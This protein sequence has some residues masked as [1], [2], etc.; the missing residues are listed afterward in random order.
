MAMSSDSK[1]QSA[2]APTPTDLPRFV[3]A[4]P[5]LVAMQSVVGR[6]WQPVLLYELAEAEALGF[7]DLKGRVDGVSSKMLSES[8][9]RLEA[10]GLVARRL[11]NEKPVRVEYRLTDA[12]TDLVPVLRQLVAWGSEHEPTQGDEERSA[13][14]QEGR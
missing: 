12:G 5:V 2:D 11:L 14:P 7:S 10:Q 1:P 8:L 4:Q 3:D 9:D 13:G 6:T